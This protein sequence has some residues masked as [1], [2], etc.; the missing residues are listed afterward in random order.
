MIVDFTVH[1]PETVQ[2]LSD[3]K[4]FTFYP[5]GE[6]FFIG[7]QHGG[8][9][10]FG[11]PYRFYVQDTPE[12]RKFLQANGF[13]VSDNDLG[14]FFNLGQFAMFPQPSM[15]PRQMQQPMHSSGVAAKDSET[16]RDVVYSKCT[17]SNPAP[18]YV[19]LVESVEML[20]EA[21]EYLNRTRI[22]GTF[23][24]PNTYRQML[25]LIL[26]VSQLDSTSRWV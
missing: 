22:N 4:E 23:M 5:T 13:T 6:R 7:S 14:N 26:T 18:V 15:Y 24:A 10:I 3:N 16:V 1:L 8:G 9:D 11:M 19:W 25:E 17:P 12:A 21:H 2:L 20:R